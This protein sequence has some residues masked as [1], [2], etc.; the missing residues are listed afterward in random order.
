MK[1]VTLYEPWAMLVAI[2][3]KKIE[4]RSWATRYRGALAIHAGKNWP[5]W[6]KLF[7]LREPFRSVLFPMDLYYPE[8]LPLGAIVAI[9]DL[10]DCFKIDPGPLLISDQ[11][12]AFGDYIPGRFMW[13][14]GS[15]KRVNPPIPAKGKQGLWDWDEKP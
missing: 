15:V 6:A 4:T 1:A 9:C 2:E 3:A 8:A 14:L 12:K 13:M 10:E 7:L 11:E 5:S